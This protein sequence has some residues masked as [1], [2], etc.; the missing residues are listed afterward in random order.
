[1]MAEESTTVVI[2]GGTGDLAQRKLV[3]ALFTLACKGRLPRGLRVFAFARRDYSDDRYREYMWN[4]ARE[5]GDLAARRDE[6]ELFAKNMYYVSGDIDDPDS[7]ARLK[8]RLDGLDQGEDGAANRLYYL[9]VAPRFFE[10]AIKNIAV[11]G[12]A[13]EDNGWRRAVIEKPFGHDLESAQKLNRV[14]QEVFDEHQVYRIDHY[15]GKETVQNLLV[16]RFANAIFEPIWNRNYIDNVQITVAESVSVGDRGGYYDQ[17]GVVRD[18]VQNH[19]FQLLTLVA[20][21]PPNVADSESLR[22][23]K[24]EVLQAIRRPDRGELLRSAVRGQYEGY[25]GENGV[26]EDSMTPTYAAMRL[27]VDN[28]R[29]RDVPFYI[30]TGKAMAYK[31]SEIVIQ[32]Q[33]PPH[34]L[35][36]RG[37][38]VD[39]SSNVLGICL[40]PDEGVHL[41]FQVKV[42]GQG[43]EMETMDMAFHYDSGFQEESIPEAYER[44]LQDAL[45]GDASLFIR[46]DHIEEAWN[47]VDPLLEAWSDGRSTSDAPLHTYKPGSWGPTAGDELLS[48]YGH[49]WQRVCGSHEADGN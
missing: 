45:A 26:G 39:T 35:F 40:Q 18:M 4:G 5:I 29:W 1:M 34:S 22:N 21:E 14:V 19:L 24:V 48:R 7:F 6:W 10:K 13:D 17:S 9:S 30:R 3:P 20:M 46:K 38:T 44:L 49:K 2:I 11:A 47:I 33:K 16:F 28:W 37:P 42:P 15:L 41:K 32:F 31:V 25:L 36:Q 27:F 23:K 43:L 8:N 12:L